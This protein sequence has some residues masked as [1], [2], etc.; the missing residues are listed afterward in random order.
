MSELDPSAYSAPFAERLRALGVRPVLIGALAALRYRAT[1]R[2]TTDADYLASSVAGLAEAMTAEGFDV[3]AL[4]QPGDDEPYAVFIRGHGL[5]V[6]VLR[7][8]TAFQRT[9]L[10]RAVDGVITAEDVI[11]F[12]LVAWRPRDQDDIASILEAG[13]DLDTAYIERWAAEWQVTDR[14]DEARRR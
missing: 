7:A 1:P 4:T 5:K 11:V 8:E 6:D 2:F 10:E 12:K 3:R 9:A 13:H 14:W